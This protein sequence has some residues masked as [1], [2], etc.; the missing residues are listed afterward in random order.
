MNKSA[1]AKK[2]RIGKRALIIALVMVVIAGGCIASYSVFLNPYRGVTATFGPTRELHQTITKQQAEQDLDYLM[3]RIRERHP[4]WLDG[5]DDLVFRVT[6]QYQTE[7]ANLN[8]SE[9]VLSLWQAAARICA[10]LEDGHTNVW[11]N[12]ADERLYIN[13]FTQLGQYGTPAKINHTDTDELYRVFLTQFPYET[14]AYARS[15]FKKLILRRQYLEFFGVDTAEG[16]TFTFDTPEGPAEYLYTFVAAPEI[17]GGNVSGTGEWVSYTIDT[18]NDTGVFT[19]TEC[20][21]NEEYLST[22]DEFFGKVFENGLSNVIVD[23]RGN[24][25]GNSRVANEFLRYVDVDSYRAWDSAVRFGPILIHNKDIVKK[26][27]RKETVFDG[28]LYVLT[29]LHSYSSAMDFAMLVG[30]N[31][32]GVLVGEASGNMP[33][34]YGD[35]LSFQ[36]PQAGLCV[37]ISYKK[38]FRIDQSKSESPLTPDYECAPEQALEKAYELI[39]KT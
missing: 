3:N 4:A 15:I 21:P 10:V 31:D 25:G 37:G 26:N 7:L 13:D 34:S 14:E 33:S 6:E 35:V 19:L 11:I 30:D 29:D 18:A 5:S 1:V 28:N 2:K 23:L 17:I 32:I 27:D 16:V 38:W 24:G 8:E 12:P 22:L 39:H 20:N 36:T 9:T